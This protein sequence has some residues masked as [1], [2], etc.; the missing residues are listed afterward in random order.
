MAGEKNRC[1]NTWTEAKFRSFVKGNLRQATMKWKP[2][3][4]VKKEAR[5]RRGFYL[6]AECRQ[7]VPATTKP[8]GSRRIKNVHVDHI[9]AVVNPAKGWEGWDV[10]IERLFS[11]KEGLRVLCAACHKVVTD[12]EKQIAKERRAQEKLDAE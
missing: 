1:S 6:C 3:Q 7:E 5:T 4:D 10:L 9:E 8:E 2:I 12:E 11:E